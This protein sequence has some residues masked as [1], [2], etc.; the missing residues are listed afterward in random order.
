[1][2]WAVHAK[3]AALAEAV[4]WRAMGLVRVLA[5][6]MDSFGHPCQLCGFRFRNSG[7]FPG[8]QPQ[9]SKGCLVGGRRLADAAL[10]SS[11]KSGP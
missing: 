7:K 2:K 1:M 9:F 8:A 3:S 5:G 6:I 10:G 11:K 4:L